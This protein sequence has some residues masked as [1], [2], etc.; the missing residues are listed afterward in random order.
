[1]R[2]SN[3]RFSSCWGQRLQ[4]Q[5]RTYGFAVGLSVSSA[6]TVFTLAREAQSLIKLMTKQTDP[7]DVRSFLQGMANHARTG[8]AMARRV[9]T[10]FKDVERDVNLVRKINYLTEILSARFFH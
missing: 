1:M 6:Q 4:V 10:R 8:L 5:M 2:T 3:Y 7:S 9:A